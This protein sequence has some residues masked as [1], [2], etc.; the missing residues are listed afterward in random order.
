MSERFDS[1][2]IQASIS[3]DI[4]ERLDSLEVLARVDSTNDYLLRRRAPA[5]GQFRV[6]VTGHQTAGRGQFQRSWESPPGGGLCMSIAYTFSR[7]AKALSALSLALGVA[8]AQYLVGLGIADACLKWPNDIIASDGKLGGILVEI[9]GAGS[10]KAAV[11][12]GIGLNLDL[13]GSLEHLE[14]SSSVGRIVDV[15]QCLGRSLPPSDLAAG[16]A[17]SLMHA[18]ISF[19]A[20]GFSAFRDTWNRVDWLRGREVRVDTAA[21]LIAGVACG[22]DDDGALLVKTSQGVHR[23]TSGRVAIPECEGSAA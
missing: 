19:D 11:V 4:V 17:D 6:A 7:K 21:A 12:A 2:R 14:R 16:V 3:Q 5:P 18:T 23:V 13:Q 1:R 20:H 9:R 22:V 10:G 8:A 15:R